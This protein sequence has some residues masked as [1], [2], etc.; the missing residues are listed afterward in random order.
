[1]D[2]TIMTRRRRH[3]TAGLAVLALVAAGG[4]PA[5]AQAQIGGA[6]PGMSTT[7]G[8]VQPSPQTPTLP[9]PLTTTPYPL[10]APVP[11]RAAPAAAAVPAP[12]AVPAQPAN[13]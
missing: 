6:L 11:Q 10:S 9:G 13:R 12:A 1:M 5:W 4:A 8:A 7:Q 3:L 2:T